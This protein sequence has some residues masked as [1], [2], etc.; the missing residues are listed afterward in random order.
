LLAV[1]GNGTTHA[2]R[3]PV[4]QA[5]AEILCPV[6]TGAALSDRADEIIGG[7]S[8]QLGP[9]I[10]PL[11]I[12]PFLC[13]AARDFGHPIRLGSPA[14][15]LI[16]T[17]KGPAAED[18]RWLTGPRVEG[19]QVSPADA[20]GCRA[21][22]PGAQPWCIGVEIW[23]ALDRFAHRTYA[24]ATEASRAGAGSSDRDSD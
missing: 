20:A 13:R 10:E 4:W 14:H 22:P 3:P 11:L 6:A 16:A 8:L 24:P 2:P 17:P 5:E 12:V 9:V 18:W 21:A 7:A 1:D 15:E 19:L 23:R